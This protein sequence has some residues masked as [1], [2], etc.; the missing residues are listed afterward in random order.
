MDVITAFKESHAPE[1]FHRHVAYLDSQ[2]QS[3]QKGLKRVI[4]IFLKSVRESTHYGA[5]QVLIYVF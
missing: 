3:G 5:H 2:L 1:T 4:L